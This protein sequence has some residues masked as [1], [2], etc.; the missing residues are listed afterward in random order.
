LS[1]AGL[2]RSLQVLGAPSLFGQGKSLAGEEN[3]VTQRK[4]KN[5]VF[6]GK[7]PTAEGPRPPAGITATERAVW[8]WLIEATGESGV[9][10]R[11]ADE[12]L[13]LETARTWLLCESLV[14][15]IGSRHMI[16][17]RREGTE[18]KNPLHSIL[19]S[20]R[21][22]LKGYFALL[23]MAPTVRQSLDL[24]ERQ[25]PTP[26]NPNAIPFSEAVKSAR[27]RNGKHKDED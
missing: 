18:V 20:A 21:T 9:E 27:S 16:A 11:R 25:P 12:M 10:L 19:N 6:S 26:S 2:G 15:K 3:T 17:G 8:D 24:L 23:G 22:A 14:K 4:P 5:V 7:Q 13:L 1:S